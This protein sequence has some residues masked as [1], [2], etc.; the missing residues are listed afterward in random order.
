MTNVPINFSTFFKEPVNSLIEDEVF[1]PKGFDSLPVDWSLKSR[2]FITSKQNFQW[3]TTLRTSEEAS[4]VTSFSRCL[5]MTDS[6]DNMASIDTGANARFHQKCLYWQHPSIP[7][8]PLFP[9]TNKLSGTPLLM[10]EQA[11]NALFKD[12]QESFHS[13]VT[14]IRACQC[15]YIYVY[16][17]NFLL[18]LRAAGISGIAEIHAIITPTTRGLRQLLT[19]EVNL[20][21]IL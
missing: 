2:M 10:E 13:A 20:Y 6:D 1:E 17:S 21:K 7:W 4:G 9:R 5:S 15:P 11:Q 12:W 8:L 18:L 14:L 3:S 19:Q 16:A